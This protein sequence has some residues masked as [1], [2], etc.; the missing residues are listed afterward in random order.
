MGVSAAKVA[1]EE[2]R[3]TAECRVLVADKAAA[4]RGAEC[5]I[6]CMHLSRE[7]KGSFF[8]V[9]WGNDIMVRGE[10]SEMLDIISR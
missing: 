1:G 7:G 5:I 6:A 10:A 2:S 9:A 4:S 8:F 3:L